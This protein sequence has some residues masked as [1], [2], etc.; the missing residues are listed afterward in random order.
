V[1]GDAFL[2]K[3]YTA[4]DFTN[5]R[6]GFAKAAK[7]S[8]DRC[9]EDLKLDITHVHGGGGDEPPTP[10]TPHG[11]SPTQTP[12]SSSTIGNTTFQ[13]ESVDAN[14]GLK[15]FGTAAAVLVIFAFLVSLVMRRGSA[16]KRRRFEEIV[17]K[18]DEDGEDEEE[19]FTIDVNKLNRM[20]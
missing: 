20:N 4:F 3:Y 1:L 11:S 13:E 16:A 18:A 15:R 8:A 2:N 12:A 19:H 7:N 14:S 17:S 9:D 10:A 5:K 6:L